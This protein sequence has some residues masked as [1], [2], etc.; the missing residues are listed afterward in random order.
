MR[1]LGVAVAFALAI[2]ACGASDTAETTTTVTAP[3]TTTSTGAETTTTTT[4]PP[5]PTTLSQVVRAPSQPDTYKFLVVVDAVVSEPGAT[6]VDVTLT[7]EG[8]YVNES[9]HYV[10]E[11]WAGGFLFSDAEYVVIDDEGWERSS[12]KP[13]VEMDALGRIGV[14]TSLPLTDRPRNRLY[15]ELSEREWV[16]EERGSYTVRHYAWDV[17]DP[18]DLKDWFGIWMSD[19]EGSTA[20]EIDV[21]IDVDTE[22]LIGAEV[23]LSGNEALMPGFAEDGATIDLV[24]SMEFSFLGAD[25][26]QIE[27][28]DT[29]NS[30]PE[31]QFL[32]ERDQFGFRILLPIDWDVLPGDETFEGFAIALNATPDSVIDQWVYVTVE[33]L[34]GTAGLR[35]DEYADV[36]VDFAG[37]DAEDWETYVSEATTV[38]EFPAWL[39]QTDFTGGVVPYTVRMISVIDGNFGYVLEFYG[40]DGDF[41]RELADSIFET[42]EIYERD[43]SSNA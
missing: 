43:D 23:R 31:G 38:G 3:P 34:T 16:V 18:D 25:L 27:E 2:T 4:M 20:T 8:E 21:W 11:G 10:D 12:S 15:S 24:M 1:T 41:D 39:T 17:E 14:A 6:D 7:S 42:F 30:A 22:A 35:V 28:P 37:F 36:N 40:Y 29:T 9:L 19:L 33:D 5:V 13:W 32:F 26:A